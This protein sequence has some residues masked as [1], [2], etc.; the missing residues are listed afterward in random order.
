MQRLLIVSATYTGTRVLDNAAA[1]G[2]GKLCTTLAYGTR[3]HFIAGLEDV[4]ALS[5]LSLEDEW[6]RDFSWSDWKG[7]TYNM[8]NEFVYV[9]GPASAKV[10]CTCLLYTSP[11][12]RDS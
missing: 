9:L 6:S 7:H 11:S 8:R 2:G 1:I 4:F 3:E 12:P 5:T 10:G